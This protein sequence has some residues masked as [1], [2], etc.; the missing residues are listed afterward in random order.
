VG[1]TQLAVEGEAGSVSVVGI[2][3]LVQCYLLDG[4]QVWTKYG[5]KGWCVCVALVHVAC[6]EWCMY[7]VVF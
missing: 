1:H 6:D 3:G 5:M 7:V 2:G 4:S